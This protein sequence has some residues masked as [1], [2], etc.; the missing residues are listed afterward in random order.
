MDSIPSLGWWPGHEGLTC[1][2]SKG[3]LR[4]GEEELGVALQTGPLP[5]PRELSLILSCPNVNKDQNLFLY[6]A[7]PGLG[8]KSSQFHRKRSKETLMPQT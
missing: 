6:Y 8:G 7:G 2:G 5:T 4:S 3:T 1:R